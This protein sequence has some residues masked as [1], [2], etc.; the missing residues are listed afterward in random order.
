MNIQFESIAFRKTPW[1]NK[2]FKNNPCGNISCRNSHGINSSLRY[3]DLY[4]LSLVQIKTRI[5][6]YLK[7]NNPHCQYIFFCLGFVTRKFRNH[8]TACKRGGCSVTGICKFCLLHRH[9]FASR[10]QQSAPL[11]VGGD[12]HSLKKLS[13]LQDLSVNNYIKVLKNVKLDNTKPFPTTRLQ[14]RTNNNYYAKCSLSKLSS[15]FVSQ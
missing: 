3:V 9:S 7:H 15:V 2:T 13:R 6:S 10:L 14:N 5:A 12:P 8:R 4:F 1:K 11:H